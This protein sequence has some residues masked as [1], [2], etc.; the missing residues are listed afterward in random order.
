MK[1]KFPF[2]ALLALLLPASSLPAQE[3]PG[4][5]ADCPMHAQ[6]ANPGAGPEL[7][8]R[9]DRVM[10]FGHQKTAH[11]FL[12][13]P[14]GGTIEVEVADEADGESRAAIQRHLEEVSEA[15]GRGDFAMPAAIHARELPGVPTLRRLRS[16][17]AYRFEK[18]AA[19]GR[20]V[21]ASESPEA[22]EAIHAFLRSQIEDHR[23]GDPLEPPGEK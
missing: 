2:S 20:V 10:G 9:G 4:A 13:S 12:L 5:M 19:G 3:A 23:T 8:R 17:I 15:F 22:R 11:H 1:P 7:D 14:A 21:I 6:H 18:T 16:E